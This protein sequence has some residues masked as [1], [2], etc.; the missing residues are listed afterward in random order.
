[1]MHIRT[2]LATL[3]AGAAMF[4]S[5]LPGSPSLRADE[6]A[7]A[8]PAAAAKQTLLIVTPRSLQKELEP[9]VEHKKKELAVETAVLEDVLA[10]NQGSDDPVKLKHFLYQAWR[11]RK[12][13]YVLL[14]GDSEVMP[15]RYM[16]LDRYEPAAF[17]YSFYPCDLY[18]ADVAK[19]D[20]SFDDWNAQK[21]GFHAQYFGEVRGEKN[22][23]DPINYDAI[24][25]RPELAVGRWPV[26]T[27]EQVRTMV[28][29]SIG[30]EKRIAAAPTKSRAA[31]IHSSGWIDA[32]WALDQEADSLPKGWIIE[33]RYYSDAARKCD[34]APNRKE[35]VNLLN[36]GVDLMLHAGHGLNDQ[37]EQSLYAHDLRRIKNANHLPVMMSIGCNTAQFCALAPY[38]PY[39]DVSGV[40][41]KGTYAGEV[42]KAPPPPPAVYQKGKYNSFGLGKEL[43]RGGPNG[44]VAYI[45][46]NTGGQPCGLSLMDGFTHAWGRDPSARLGDCWMRA[47]SYY[48]D[49]EHLATIKPNADWYP[50]SIFF[51]AMKYMFYGDPSLRLPH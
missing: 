2:I 28:A 49:R 47:V 12:V 32:R 6:P 13:H 36:S 3:A 48:Y 30:Y 10:K 21:E 37:W 25:Y 22:K 35:V 23:S 1:M 27:P 33:K 40:E 16:V 15:V 11:E 20:G 9:F 31:L 41:H 42:F 44:A 51:Q 46:C 50:P 7:K 5:G 34:P 38:E 8:K 24:H 45:G 39:V 14:V 19:A 43:L 18:Y 17:H 4:F 26:N 29:K